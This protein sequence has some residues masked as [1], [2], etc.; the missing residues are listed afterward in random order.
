[1]LEPADSQE[2]YDFTRSRHRDLGAVELAGAPAADHT[3]L[4]L[5][6]A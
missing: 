1:M 4:P 5:E 3:R 2:A 6:D